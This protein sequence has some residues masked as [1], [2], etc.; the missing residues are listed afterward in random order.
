[1]NADKLHF[2]AKIDAWPRDTATHIFL[3]RATNQIGEC[4]FG[5][6]WNGPFDVAAELEREIPRWDRSS[7][8]AIRANNILARH[9]PESGR[10]PILGMGLPVASQLTEDE[11][12][13]ARLVVRKINQDTKPGID[14]FR[15]VRDE[16]VNRSESGQLE[17]ATRPTNGGDFSP[18]P[19]SYWNIDD[20]SRRFFF[21]QLNPLF[22][23]GS[24]VAGADFCWIFVTRGSLASLLAGLKSPPQ[25]SADDHREVPP[26]ID[27]E[28]YELVSLPGKKQQLVFRAL[29]EAWKDGRIPRL[30]TI[31][32]IQERIDPI[33]KRM[34]DRGGASADNIRRSLGLK[35]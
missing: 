6:S 3:G 13:Q 15:R 28:C 32:Q 34:G 17:T 24:G 1:M 20:S 31:A 10:K 19:A 12:E 29:H 35:K 7:A 22:P 27:A 2:W 8:D 23:F 30:L 14:R 4:L 26:T 11:W 21:C 18:I 16:V 25:G 33:V 5:N 9:K